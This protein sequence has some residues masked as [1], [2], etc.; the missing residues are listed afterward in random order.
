MTINTAFTELVGCR[1]P[2][3]NAGMGTASP[4]MGTA[5]AE[6]VAGAEQLLN[7]HTRRGVE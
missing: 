5:S 2:V 4:A 7:Q 6:L 3:Q 1:H